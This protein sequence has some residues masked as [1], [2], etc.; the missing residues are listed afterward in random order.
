MND[1]LKNEVIAAL[2]YYDCIGG[3]WSFQDK[4]PPDVK[5][6]L[7]HK[8]NTTIEKIDDLS[9]D[10]CQDEYELCRPQPLSRSSEDLGRFI[11]DYG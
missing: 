5:D 3:W 10:Y 8:Y 4:I 9:R 6:Y 7:A 2:E 1:Q 11:K